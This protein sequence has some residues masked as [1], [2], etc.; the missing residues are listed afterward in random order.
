MPDVAGSVARRI[1]VNDPGRRCVLGVLEQFQS[2]ATGM[3]TEDREVDSFC[4]FVGAERQRPASAQVG[5]VAD[6]CRVVRERTF[7]AA[8]DQAWRAALDEPRTE[9]QDYRAFA[10]ADEPLGFSSCG[11]PSSRAARLKG[12][13][14]PSTVSRG[15]R[16]PRT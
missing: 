14:I 3:A 9:L 1:Q 13:L 10:L 12:V 5:A 16:S 4:V 6:C 11:E 15:R 2:D 7:A 8:G